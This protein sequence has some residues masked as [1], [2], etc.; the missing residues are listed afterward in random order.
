M[1]YE[2]L[3]YSIIQFINI[4]TLLI[5]KKIY[6]IGSY[7]LDTFRRSLKIC[8]EVNQSRLTVKMIEIFRTTFLSHNIVSHLKCFMFVLI[9]SLCL[10][11]NSTT[12][13][14]ERS[15]LFLK[16]FETNRKLP[17]KNLAKKKTVSH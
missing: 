4:S 9:C 10:S 16:V 13:N 6:V 15:C 2:K 3:F 1:F 11:T 17:V 8:V 14:S 5:T 12:Y 7:E